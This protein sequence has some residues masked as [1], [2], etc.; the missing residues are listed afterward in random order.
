MIRTFLIRSAPV[1]L[2]ALLCSCLCLVLIGPV[3][4]QTENSPVVDSLL[5]HIQE[6]HN[7][8]VMIRA[9]LASL[10]RWRGGRGLGG[11]ARV[12]IE[13]KLSQRWSVLGEVDTRYLMISGDGTLPS[14]R[15][16]TGN[17]TLSV[18]PRFYRRLLEGG[19]PFRTATGFSATYLALKISTVLVPVGT[20]SA[21]YPVYHSDNIA[22]TPLAGVQQRLWHIGYVDAGF[23]LRVNY[24]VPGALPNGRWPFR[25]GW[26]IF[27]AAQ[28]QLGLGIGK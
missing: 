13:G 27:P 18:T 23:G 26:S 14:I 9:D 4:A 21:G 11:V 28:V 5:D 6:L 25:P 8:R 19:A 3:S 17:L 10:I 16:E 7:Q 15:P 24:Q 12:G 2:K 1:M 20:G 22:F